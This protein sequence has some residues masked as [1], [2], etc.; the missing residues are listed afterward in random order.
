M[1]PEAA[2]Y[3]SVDVGS[4]KFDEQNPN[5][6]TAA[7]MSALKNS[8]REYG[9]LQPIVIDQNGNIVDGAHRALAYK[10]LGYAKIPAILIKIESD[11]DRRIIRQTMNKLRGRHDPM[12]DAQEFVAILKAN[13]E[14]KLFDMSAIK[15]TE[16]YKTIQLA[17]NEEDEDSVP[18]LPE[19]PITQFGDVWQLEQHILVCG[20]STDLQTME[21][22]MGGELANLLIT[23]PPY[24]VS[25]A[26]KNAYLNAVGRGNR[27]QIPIENDHKPAK[28][29]GELWTAVFKNASN[30]MHKG[31]NYYI[32][33]M[34]GGD[35]MMMLMQAILNANLLLKHMLIWVKNNHVLGRLDYHYKH[36]PILYGW[37]EGSHKF[38]GKNQ[39]SVW[40]VNKPHQSKLHPTMK[41]VELA[42]RAM[43]NSSQEGDIVLDPF[44]GAGYSLIAA[45]KLRR[46]WH[47][48]ELDPKYVDVI[49]KR[50][51]NYTGLTAKRAAH[52]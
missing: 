48:I 45:E 17:A 34:Q 7:Q 31:A 18:P 25:Y 16:F 26:D 30:H 28:E 36:E 2:E 24:G 51:E 44:A 9:N 37:K 12:L 47:G 8:I 21:K 43:L 39:T 19:T 27:I 29:M 41:P 40:E 22:C 15:E 14:K 3:T 13:E 49:V 23:D 6:M 38:Y 32:H 5:K 4:L 20:D 33:A 11:A 46:V 42:E 35:L 50:W 52:E 10:E 1:N